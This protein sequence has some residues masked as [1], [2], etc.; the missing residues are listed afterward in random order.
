LTRR[1]TPVVVEGGKGSPAFV[2]LALYIG[3]AGLALCMQGIEI[4]FQ[5]LFG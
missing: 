2:P 4:L 3:L 1:N 5:P